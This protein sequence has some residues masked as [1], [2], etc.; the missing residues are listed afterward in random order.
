[1]LMTL[2]MPLRLGLVVKYFGA[3]QLTLLC[4]KLICGSPGIRRKPLGCSRPSISFA[5]AKRVEPNPC[6]KWMLERDDFPLDVLNVKIHYLVC[7]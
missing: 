6:I 3:Q 2:A 5:S 7:R 1:M 4:G